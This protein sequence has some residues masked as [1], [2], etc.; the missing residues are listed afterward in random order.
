MRLQDLRQKLYSKQSDIESRKPQT[1]A[2]DPRSKST[3][4]TQS[5]NPEATSEGKDWKIETGTTQKQKTLLT[6]VASILVGI[7]VLGGG[8]Y[9]L[10]RVFKKDFKQQ[11]VQLK[12]EVPPA[13][14]LN[15][16]V[17]LSIPFANN[18]PV[19]LKDAHLVLTVPP[20]FNIVST[21]PQADSTGTGTAEWSLGDIAPQQNKSLELRGRFT[22]R[23]QDSVSFK[24]TV[25]YTPS[26]F[27]SKFQ[28]DITA[29]TKVI[30]VP[31]SLFVE[32]TRTAASGY[33]ISYQIKV[34][35]NGGEPFQNLKV[36]LTY[37]QGFSFV[38]STE[39]LIG[40]SKNAWNIPTI[41]SNEEKV[42]KID[43]K[44]E[45]VVGDQKILTVN[46]GQDD[47]A[48]FK[49]YIEK[50]ASTEVTDP[51]ISISQAVNNDQTVVHKGDPLSFTINYSN[52]ADRAIGQA[53]VKVKLEGT[54]FDLSSIEVENG[55]WYDSN[56]KEIV[57]QAGNVPALALINPGDNGKLSFRIKIASFIPFS[58]DK[59]SN[60]SGQTSVSIESPEMPTSIGADKVVTGNTLVLK[61][62]SAAG[63]TSTVFYSD[64]T[65]PNS[66][67]IPPTVG[68]KTTYTVHWTLT[69]AFNDLR[70]VEV[71]TVLPYGVDWE[72]RAF[73]SKTGVEF[74]KQT[75]VITWNLER[76]PA[77]AGIDKPSS[78]LVFQVSLTPTDDQ[79]G[80]SPDLISDTTFK[81]TDVFTQETV[82]LTARPVNTNLPD[83]KTM[84]E[85]MGRVIRPGDEVYS[86]YSGGSANSN[87]NQQ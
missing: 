66:G 19:G 85:N 56:N 36:N 2:Y 39:A 75:R 62:S 54:I 38:S 83:D 59:K 49:K 65:I 32:A 28:N 55:G 11:Q 29:S 9:V 16:E 30:G 35:N 84:D 44:I 63:L 50:N 14:N 77:G 21:N 73:P 10:Y 15:D 41:L 3:E 40:D 47:P 42:L 4:A 34:R 5:E 57:W 78:N 23:D 67:P 8:G 25:I 48:G 45:G 80:K 46:I 12:I 31:L 6:L 43:G 69:N 68:K 82:S 87:T 18:N 17:V 37:P 51:P 79:A 33:A 72:D 13:V 58:N 60:F 26:N 81:G 61:L 22:G 53:I 7:I 71:K 20:N 70:G 86:E 74:N 64:G 27:N 52:E 1:D 24:A 76:I